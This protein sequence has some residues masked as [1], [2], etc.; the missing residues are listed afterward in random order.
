MKK[1]IVT[2][3]LG[4]IGVH[5]CS[6]LIEEGI[7]VFGIDSLINDTQQRQGEERL[8]HIGR[9][10]LFHYI[11]QPIEA[12]DFASMLEEDTVV[13]HLAASTQT[14]HQWNRLRETIY[15]NVE[16]TQHLIKAVTGKGRI[17]YSSTVQ[18]YGERTGMITERTPS[19]PI[20]PYGLTK[21]AGESLLIQESKKSDLDVV[22][23]RLPTVYGPLQRE[24]MTFHQLLE[25]KIQNKPFPEIVD[26]STY[27][28]LYI[29]DVVEGLLLA[30]RTKFVNEVYN[31]SSG[32]K[33]QWF[34][35]KEMI[36]GIKD[37]G[38]KNAREEVFISNQ[39]SLDKLGFNPCT[40][41]EEGIK[42]QE[43]Y[44]KKRLNRKQ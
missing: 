17:V 8:L 11:Q 34:K 40:T 5:L 15:H 32:K 23:V 44:L 7:E 3:A 9:N 21:M 36:T 16:A 42:K 39:K 33:R 2:G 35:G 27:D 24:D 37:K 14:D 30:G 4:F 25:A 29:E 28:I 20:N 6:R 38:W 43:E 31:F 1:A 18:V 19:N 13:F 41:V 22:I 12:V 10:S 26:R